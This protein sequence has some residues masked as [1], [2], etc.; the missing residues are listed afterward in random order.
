MRSQSAAMVLPYDLFVFT[1]MHETASLSLGLELG[2]Y[3]HFCGSLHYYT[4]EEEIVSRMLN[5]QIDNNSWSMPVM[6]SNPLE[7][8]QDL[9]KIERELRSALGQGGDC[10]FLRS[11]GLSEYWVAIF[12]VI[13]ILMQRRLDIPVCDSLLSNIPES[14]KYLIAHG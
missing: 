14:F 10:S 8:I 9:R 5:E 13:A 12:S 3:H 11:A 6:D 1:M 7:K 4:D 2:A